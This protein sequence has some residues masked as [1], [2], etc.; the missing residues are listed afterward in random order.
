LLVLRTVFLQQ[1]AFFLVLR[2]DEKD[3]ARAD[4]DR[5]DPGF[6]GV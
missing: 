1:L 4:Q 5:D 2:Q 3:Q 6:W